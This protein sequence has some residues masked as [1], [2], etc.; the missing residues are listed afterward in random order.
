MGIV[1]KEM[2]EDCEGVKMK[3]GSNAD[4]N[5]ASTKK[6]MEGFYKDKETMGNVKRYPLDKIFLRNN[7]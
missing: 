3:L 5:A 6:N 4:D 2:V 1:G 7:Q